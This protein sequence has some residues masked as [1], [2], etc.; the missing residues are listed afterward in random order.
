MDRRRP[1]PSRF[2]VFLCGSA[3]L[4]V[5]GFL[6]AAPQSLGDAAYCPLDPGRTHLYRQAGEASG[7]ETSR[8]IIGSVTLEAGTAAEI[9]HRV[10]RRVSDYSYLSARAD[11]VYRHDTIYIGPLR[12][13]R[14]AGPGTCVLPFPVVPGTVREFEGSLRVQTS[15][16]P[17]SEEERERLRFKTRIEVLAVDEPVEVPAGRFLCARVAT[18]Q[19]FHDGRRQ[20]GVAYYARHIGLVKNSRGLELVAFGLTPPPPSAEKVLRAAL[21]APELEPAWC[22]SEAV[23]FLR[24]R[25][26]RVEGG[27]TPKLYRVFGAKA[28]PFE[29]GEL[30]DWRLL[31]EEEGIDLGA[32]GAATLFPMRL[33][34]AAAVLALWMAA[35]EAEPAGHGSSTTRFEGQGRKATEVTVRGGG[36]AVKGSVVTEGR[37]LVAVRVVR[38]E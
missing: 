13:V 2:S 5:A 19:T 24:S 33:A 6:A 21:E 17:L 32:G 36:L 8:A 23:Q 25:F 15:G 27:K 29:P 22:G 16:E 37:E 14:G 10:G 31:L 28:E 1:S 7:I 35:P 4:V 30:A 18:T 38:G 11:G 3:Q 26:A 20:E 9:E 12:G 34:G